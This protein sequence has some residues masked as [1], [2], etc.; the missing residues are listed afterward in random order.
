M[1]GHR[2]TFC[3]IGMGP[4]RDAFTEPLQALHSIVGWEVTSH[5]LYR[6]VIF[7]LRKKLQQHYSYACETTAEL[8][9][10]LEDS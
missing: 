8:K 1:R 10:K 7:Y 3:Q 9:Q 2:R 4:V 5:T 6:L